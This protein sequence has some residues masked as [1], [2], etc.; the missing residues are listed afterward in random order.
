[1]SM[2]RESPVRLSTVR[3]RLQILRYSLMP[4]EAIWSWKLFVKDAISSSEL[5][6]A[7]LEMADDTGRPAIAK[8]KVICASI[9]ARIACEE[10]L[11][12]FS[13]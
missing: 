9:A 12:E 3:L 1:M 13:R 6:D 5:R 4:T 2:L 7:V 10:S 11:R 8:S